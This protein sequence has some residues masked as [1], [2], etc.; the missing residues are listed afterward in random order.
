MCIKRISRGHG[1]SPPQDMHSTH[2][3]SLVSLQPIVHVSF[4]QGETGVPAENAHKNPKENMQNKGTVSPQSNPEPSLFEATMLTSA[5]TAH[6]T[7]ELWH[8]CRDPC[9]ATLTHPFACL[10]IFLVF[11]DQIFSYLDARVTT[12]SIQRHMCILHLSI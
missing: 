9:C 2:L 1:I 5:A 7:H 11:T 4:L 6:N 8:Q 3:R 12:G 10:F